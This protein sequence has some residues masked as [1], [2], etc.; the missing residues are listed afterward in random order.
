M[1]TLCEK[2]IDRCIKAD[3]ENPL[4]S[5]VNA[6]ALIF[7]K[8]H[9]DTVTWNG[10]NGNIATGITMKVKTAGDNPV[11]YCAYPVEQLGKRPY[12][13][14]QTE[15]V[16]G[17]YGNKFTH[18]IVLAIPDNGPDIAH[19]IV[20][21]LANGTFCLILQNDYVHETSA[22]AGTTAG[23]N[24]YQMYGFKK[25]LKATAITREVWGDNDSAW[26]VTLTEENA[27]QSANFFF[28]TDESTT[29]AA[30]EALKCTC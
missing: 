19:D 16:E 8:K 22:T 7:N 18:T 1:A 17:T 27:P 11:L 23:D 21:G 6:E 10:T 24:K 26:I 9:I 13:G 14:S 25:G 5:G 20:D 2:T 3:C 12:E 29:D 30:I 28:A 15:M 4:F